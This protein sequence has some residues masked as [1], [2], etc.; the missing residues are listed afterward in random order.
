MTTEPVTAPINAW[1]VAQLQFDR[2]AERLALDPG[3]RDVLRE[4]RRALTVHF[5]VRMDDG[6]SRSSPATACSTTCARPGQG[7]HPLPSGRDARRGQGARL[8]DDLEVRGRQPPVRRRQGRRHRRPEAALARARALSRRYT[9]EIELL[10]GPDRDVPAPDVNTNAQIMAWFMDTYSMHAGH[11]APASSPASR[12]ASAAPRGATRRPR[13]AS[14][15]AS[16]RRRVTSTSTPRGPRSPSRV[17]GTSARPRRSSWS[18]GARSSRS[19]TGPAASTTRTG[20]TSGQLI[21]LEAGA[22]DR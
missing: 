4:P 5:P 19:P 17:S 22:R 18:T 11:T 20:S 16:A 12:S 14:S 1:D 10:I 21:A 15:T 9:A 3:L 13:A 7:R 8:L 6:R 2:A